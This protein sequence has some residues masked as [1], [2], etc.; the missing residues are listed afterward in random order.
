MRQILQFFSAPLLVAAAACGGVDLSLIEGSFTATADL[1]IITNPGRVENVGG[2]VKVTGQVSGGSFIAGDLE[3][4]ASVVVNAELDR[5]L[6][7]GSGN[8]TFTFRS[9]KVK[10][11]VVNGGWSGEFQGEVKNGGFNGSF[12]G[13]GTRDLEN[14]R[15]EGTFSRE[16]VSS[17][18]IILTGR[19]LRS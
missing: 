2:I 12:S 4:T 5:T 15:I 11:Q 19:V 17:T 14:T 3:G 6:S 1:S 13:T 18:Q 8:G 10:G 7:N 16:S 9:T